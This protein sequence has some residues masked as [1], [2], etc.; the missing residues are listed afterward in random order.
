MTDVS[1]LAAY[2]AHM[3]RMGLG[4][5]KA[6]LCRRGMDLT[7]DVLSLVIPIDGERVSEDGSTVYLSAR[8]VEE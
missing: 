2:F 3:E 5:C 1:D 6:G 7:K 4:H 8:R